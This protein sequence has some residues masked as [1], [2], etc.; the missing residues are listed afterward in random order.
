MELKILSMNAFGYP[1][2]SNLCLN[3]CSVAWYDSLVVFV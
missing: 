2:L 3:L 1:L